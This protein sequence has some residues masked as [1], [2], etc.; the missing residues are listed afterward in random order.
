M[1]VRAAIRVAAINLAVLLTGLVA[2]EAIFGNWVLGPSYGY[3]NIPRDTVMR[4][5][6]S[7]LYAGPDTIVH[8]RDG[9]GL[10]GPYDDLSEIDIITVGGSTTAQMLIDDDDT[11]QAEMRR[12]FAAAGRPMTIVNAG[13]DG[14]S[15]VGHIAVFERWFPEIPDLEARYV[16]ALIGVNDLNVDAHAQYDVMASPDPWRRARQYVA[17]NS[18]LYNVWRMARGWL[19][20]RDAKVI[21][22]AKTEDDRPWVRAFPLDEFAMPGDADP[23]ALASYGER[24]DALID[25][26]RAFGAEA[27]IVNQHMAGYRIRDG[28]VWGKPGDDGS[29]STGQFRTIMAFNAVAMERCRARGAVCVDTA[30]RFAFEDGDLYDWVHTTPKGA[31]RLGAFLYE[32]LKDEI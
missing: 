4:R 19:R 14:Q 29:V 9:H 21:H 2:V 8:T 26:I 24:V 22:G 20:A 23:E 10:R 30:H 31:R 32:A 17:N 18:A 3:M 1:S 16:L 13:V 27:I 25:A 15:T 11:F 12:R 28:W 6:V 7:D 5:D